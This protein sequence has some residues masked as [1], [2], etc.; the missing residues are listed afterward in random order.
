MSQSP[1]PDQFARIYDKY[2]GLVLT[3]LRRQG[4][5][6]AVREDA[7]QELWTH[8]WKYMHK[9]KINEKTLAGLLA[10]MAS[11]EAVNHYRRVAQR[12]EVL[13]ETTLD[14]VPQAGQDQAAADV[15][16]RRL[17]VRGCL[18]RLAQSHPR[19]AQVLQMRWQGQ[20]NGE[21]AEALGVGQPR[22]SDLFGQACDL[23][24]PCL[25]RSLS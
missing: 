6:R 14:Q 21:V 22:A 8:L 11:Q 3:V 12:R 7:A 1:D 25:E 18:A 5:D 19:L 20:S 13:G 9:N 24:R 10:R 17:A 2:A 4:L 16:A 15:E 23:I